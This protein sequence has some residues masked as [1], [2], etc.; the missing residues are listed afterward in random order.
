MKPTD[1]ELEILQVIWQH[2]PVP[3]RFV[4]DELNRKKQVGYTTTLK[5]MQIMTEKGLLERSEKGKKH[6]YKAIIKEKEAKD[7]LLKK[8]VQT[9]FGGSAMELVIQALGN[10]Q[11]TQDELDELKALI[12]RIEKETDEGTVDI[13]S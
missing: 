13:H 12:S 3:V 4:N 9:A 2:G 1:A 11:T 6:I 10:H 5:L 8:F 7:L